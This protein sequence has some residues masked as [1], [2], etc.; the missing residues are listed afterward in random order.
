VKAFAIASLGALLTLFPVELLLA[1]NGEGVFRGRVLDQAGAPLDRAVVSIVGVN[2][3]V[4]TDR[5][6]RF[7]WSPAPTPP[8]QVIVVR[9]DGVVA[10]PI[11]VSRL[12]SGPTDVRLDTLAHEALTVVGVAPSIDAA[13]AAGTTLLSGAQLAERT[14]EN[15]MQALE[16]I[17][18]VNQVS[19]GH[20]SVPAIRGLARGRT[21]FLIDGARVSAE[22]RVGPS[23]TFLDPVVA[24]GIDVARGPGS[25]AYGSDALGGVVSVRTRR[26]E[27]GSP[28]RSRIT[29]A[30]GVGVPQ[31]RGSVEVSKGLDRGGILVQA[32]ARD[33]EDYRSAEGE[34]FNSGWEDRGLL[35]RFAHALGEGVLTTT[36]Q[37]D[38]GR[39]FER[40]RNN[41]RAVR[42]YY[43]FENSH[44]LTASYQTPNVAGFDAM[45]FTGF[46]G[47]YEQRTDQDR[48]PT[49]TSGRSIERADVSA[50]DFHLKATGQKLFARSRL[51][52]GADVNGRF[53]LEA[54]DVLQG[55]DLAGNL[56]RDTTNVSVDSARRI[57]AALFAQADVALGAVGR[58]S[59]GARVD[60]VTTRNVA[61]FFGDRSTSN[62]ALSGFGA[63]TVGSSRGWSA[64]AQV[65]RGFRDPVLSDRYFRG[66]SGR[67][68]IT[69]NPD[70]DPEHSLQF[71]LSTRY[72]TSRAQV[73]VY[74]YQY[75]IDDLI[76]RYQEQPDFF[77]FRN[78]GRGRLRGVEVEARTDLGAGY[79]VELGFQRSSGIAVGDDAALDDISPATYSLLGRKQFGRGYALVHLAVSADDDRP[80]PTEIAAPGSSLV[81][82]GGGWRIS[83]R[84]EV[85]GLVRNL[86]DDDY[87]ASPDARFVLAPGR[88]VLLSATVQF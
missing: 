74:L 9:A 75:R 34:V 19:E 65:S 4:L 52:V 5:D 67:G 21:L 3:S 87:Y 82:L 57:D 1:Q 64:T 7:S 23:A 48:F 10:P 69:G 66:P 86:F 54:L 79:S 80:G 77:F 45:E 40:P 60:R 14:P 83:G 24:E 59:A 58:A 70:L 76:E 78:R 29:G 25:V 30:Y 44:R 11:V 13:P 28:L 31:V 56:V 55:F 42:F 20:A 6:G 73:A 12:D 62:T 41:S 32:H 36:W 50:K 72:T 85:R 68:F 22:R 17:P 46:V 53:G 81:D 39:D 51:E 84:I 35:G 88:S 49:G 63:L 33:A 8:F 38:F 15:L 18:G 71:D 61:G 26:A 47:T 2:G 37:S 43:P 16:T 27:P